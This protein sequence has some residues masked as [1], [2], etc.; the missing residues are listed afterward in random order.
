LKGIYAAFDGRGEKGLGGLCEGLLAQQK[1]AWGDLR[2]GYETLRHVKS[3]DLSLSGSTVRLQYNPGR[4]KSTLAEVEPEKTRLRPC[5]LCPANLPDGQAGI[6]YREEY[7]ILGNPMPVFASHFTV[8][9]LSHRPQAIAGSIPAILG[10]MADFSSNWTILYNGPRCGASAPDHFHLQA[11]PSGNLPIEEELRQRGRLEPIHRDHHITLS[12]VK[13]LGREAVLIEGSD[14]APVTGA[15]NALLDALRKVLAIEDEPM[16]SVAGL[17]AE[18]TWRLIVFPRRSHRPDAFFREGEER[19]AV[20]PAAMEMAGVIVTPVEIDFQRL[21]G[22]S[23]EAIF[24]EVSLPG[25]TVDEAVE[26]LRFN[27]SLQF[28]P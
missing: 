2:K 21:D 12:R 17:F 25:T 24:E 28:L 14:R 6:L 3:R 15:F 5:F 16:I 18:G 4:A 20:S 19:I 1:S 7:L 11:L 10:V 27:K 23:V 13:G 9:H 22:P 26:V 8:S